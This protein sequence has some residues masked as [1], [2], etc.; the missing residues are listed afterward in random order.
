MK[1]LFYLSAI[2]FV[3]PC[4]LYA[5]PTTTS[6]RIAYNYAAF[7]LPGNTIQAP[8]TDYILGGTNVTFGGSGSILRLDTQGVMKWAKIYSPVW[9]INDVK[10]ISGGDNIITGSVVGGG[11][12]GLALMRITSSGSVVWG[13]SYRTNALGGN[14][15]D[16]NKVIQTSDGGFLSA[17][18][19]YDIDPDGGGAQPTFDSANYFIVKTNS[20]GT[21]SW[22]RAILPTLAFENDHALNDV[23][24]VSDGYI[25]VGYMSENGVVGDDYTDAVILKTDL[26]GNFLW[27]NKYGA[28]GTSQSFNSA[29]TLP[30]GEVLICGT[31][32]VRATYLRISSAGAIASGYRY[33][34]G[35]LPALEGWSMFRTSDGNYAMMGMYISFGSFN[36]FLFKLNS[37]NG[38]QIFGKRY[39]A[40]GGFFPEGQQTA[41]GGYVMNMMSGTFSWDYLILKT[42]PTGQIPAIGT[43][44]G[45]VNYTPAP[46]AHGLSATAVTPTFVSVS[47]ENALAI[48]PVNISP[49]TNTECSYF[50]PV[51][52]ISF[53]AVLKNSRVELTWKTASEQNN[54]YFAVERSVDGTEWIPVGTVQG[55]GN[56]SSEINYSFTDESFPQ[57][58]QIY[59]RL[60][61]TDFDG[62][63]EFIGPVSVLLASLQEDKLVIQ[64]VSSDALS[65]T[66]FSDTDEAITLDILDLQGRVILR[67]NKKIIK[68]SNFLQVDISG[69][70]QGAYFVQ[71]SG[72]KVLIQKKFIKL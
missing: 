56:S 11:S 43:C 50:I 40:F 51:Q 31:N 64:N 15:E 35:F 44:T 19:A 13:K 8:N 12:P 21:L 55:A 70:E 37:T 26:S 60:K 66:L 68:G 22:A 42:D 52:M 61:Q 59:Y 54:D 17:G 10:N 1:R 46:S 58:H 24:E 4:V 53:D 57:V 71:A 34:S 6:F 63:A 16:G 3:V 72:N 20:V 47:N 29:V 18:Y 38:T 62:N 9:G 7:D 67:E 30:S 36:S 45:V 32:D 49:T 25:F 48:T 39:P 5:Q 33:G 69:M 14:S 27:M 28:S 2:F 23:A 65:G 41:D